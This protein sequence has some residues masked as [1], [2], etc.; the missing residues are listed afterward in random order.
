[1][2]FFKL[3][4][5]LPTAQIEAMGQDPK[6][7]D[8]LHEL[9]QHER[10]LNE[11]TIYD[12]E[13]PLTFMAIYEYEMKPLFEV[14]KKCPFPVHTSDVTDEALIGFYDTK[15]SQIKEAFSDPRFID[16]LNRFILNN[17]NKNI[18]LDKISKYG[19]ISLSDVDKQILNTF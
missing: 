10:G 19:L 16:F 9:D 4:S 13:Y 8:L 5:T 17:A 18:V 1:M 15:D 11:V 7:S 3:T 6:Y 14:Y 2:R 12:Q